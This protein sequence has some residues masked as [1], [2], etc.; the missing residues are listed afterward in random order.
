MK[1]LFIAFAAC[2]LSVSYSSQSVDL[3]PAPGTYLTQHTPEELYQSARETE[4]WFEDFSEGI[5]EGWV[6]EE[7]G[8]IAYWEYRGQE[9]TPDLSIGTRGSCISDDETGGEPIASA[10]WANGFVIFDSNYWDDNIGPCGNFGSGPGPGPH[11]ATFTTPSIDFS[12]YEKVGLAFTQYHKNWQAETK[13]LVSVSGGEFQEIFANEIGINEDTGLDMVVRRNISQW[14]GSQS[15][16]RI[17]FLFEG[18]YYFWMLDDILFFELDDNNLYLQQARYGDYDGLNTE[19]VITMEGL[20]YTIYPQIMQPWLEFSA[21]VSN[22]GAQTQ[23]DVSCYVDLVKVATMDTIYSDN[24]LPTEMETDETF[25]LVTND[26]NLSDEM[27]DY[28]I[29]YSIQQTQIEETPDDNWARRDFIVS[30]VQF[31]RDQQAMDNVYISPDLFHGNPYEVGNFFLVSESGQEAHSISVGVSVGSL[32][33][34]EIYGAIYTMDWAG[35][36]T[37]TLVAETEPQEV[38]WEALNDFDEQVMMVLNFDTPVPLIAGVPYLAMINCPSGPENVLFAMSG[39]SP[40]FSSMIRFGV[41]SW[42]YMQYI[43]MVRLNLGIVVDIENPVAGSTELFQNFPNP[44]DH[45]TAINYKL[46][47]PSS[48]N[49]VVRDVEG[50]IVRMFEEGIKP[51]GEHSII[52]SRDDLRPGV[53][54]YTMISENAVGTKVMVID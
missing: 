20:E 1:K 21:M 42:F 37:A 36:I 44:F 32:T 26:Y 40:E 43:P 29:H 25:N 2:L 34:T 15:D 50:R 46:D 18:S 8:G 52:V 27:G 47:H 7:A 45:T 53:Y 33:G 14:A 38:Y 39:E 3:D 24:S 51:A 30:D 48:V 35:G 19:N 12:D 11:T 4:I 5:G 9:T 23:T 6:N 17:K 16:V 49:I 22:Y 10:S 41:A 31:G 13:V 54:T 28:Q